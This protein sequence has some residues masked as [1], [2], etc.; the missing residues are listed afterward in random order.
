MLHLND[1]IVFQLKHPLRLVIWEASG[2]VFQKGIGIISVVSW[3]EQIRTL[4]NLTLIWSKS[5]RW[6]HV[7]W[8]CEWVI[9]YQKVRIKCFLIARIDVGTGGS[10]FKLVISKFMILIHSWTIH[11]ILIEVDEFV[12]SIHRSLELISI[13]LELFLKFFLIQIARTG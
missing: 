2:R 4:T 10:I 13:L 11:V 3:S 12:R 1:V 9:V 6:F 5:Y 7:T 8:N